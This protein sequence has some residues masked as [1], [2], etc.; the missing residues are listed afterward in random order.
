MP[1]RAKK[2]LNQTAIAAA[3]TVVHKQTEP[4]GRRLHPSSSE[5]ANLR[6]QWMD[7]YIAAGGELEGKNLRRKPPAAP[8]EPCP[9][10]ALVVIVKDANGTP[11]QDV[12][13][14]VSALGAKRTSKDGIADYGRITAGTYSVKAKKTGHTPKRNGS[15]GEDFKTGITVT[16]G[17]KMTVNLVQHPVCANASFFEGS[18]TLGNYF[19]FD[20]KTNIV[21]RLGTDEYWLPTPARGALT[22]PTDKE[23][24]DGGRWVS[25]A[26]GEETEVEINF[27]FQGTDCIPCIANSTFEITSA[28]IADVVTTNITAQKASFKIK[29]KAEGE[30][31]LKVVCDGKDIGW[32]HIWCENEAAL[33]VDVVNLIT[34]RAPTNTFSLS[35]LRAAFNEIY[36]QAVIKIDM[37]SLGSVDLTGNTALATTE[38]SG[39]PAAGKFLAKTGSPRPYDSKGSILNALDIAASAILSSRT[40]G[41]LPRIGAYRIYRYIPT[42]GAAIG[43]TVLGIGASPAFAF[44][45]DSAH[46]RNSMAHEFGHCLGLKHPSDGSSGSQYAAH[47]RS[48][49]NQ[50]VAGFAATNTEPASSPANAKSNVMANDPTNLMGYW[51]DK[52]NR[53]PIRYHQWKT[54]SRS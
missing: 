29:G 43:G 27:A 41:T 54:C 49:L 33:K 6:D 4:P 36:R 51:S 53:K 18:K 22:M 48:T 8:V 11:V 34:N 37:I 32:F 47:N 3:N 39:Y 45:A 1:R 9:R 14:T 40:T 50:A 16:D 10:G 12:D 17:S 23:T 13:V 24:R 21:T 44:M 38:N 52:A 20:H 46:A 35:S 19:G 30:A 2:P 25:V 15:R 7:A 31:S 26:V 28:T 42:V 5:D